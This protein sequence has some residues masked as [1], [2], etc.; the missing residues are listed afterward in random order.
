[1]G[2][3]EEICSG[4]G[5]EFVFLFI[6]LLAQRN[7]PKK[8]HPGQGLQLSVDFQSH[9][10]IQTA[11]EEVS[12]SRFLFRNPVTMPGRMSSLGSADKNCHH[13]RAERG[14]TPINKA[15]NSKKQNPKQ[16]S[17]RQI[18]NKFKTQNSKLK[19]CYQP[20]HFVYLPVN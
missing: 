16:I 2:P 5:A 17:N 14:R 12:A 7:E 3:P 15:S 10:V 6:S 19:T 9:L 4:I 18:P 8:G 20:S 11:P 1:V 13:D